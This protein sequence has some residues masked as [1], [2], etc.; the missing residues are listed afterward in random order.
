MGKLF[1]IGVGPG[2]P[3]LM[4]LKALKALKKSNVVCFAGKS[5]DT[6][7]LVLQKRQCLR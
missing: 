1:G 7:L 2:D 4:T 6:L 3:D 5:E